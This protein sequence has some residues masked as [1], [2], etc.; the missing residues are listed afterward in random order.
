M[1]KHNERMAFMAREIFA[2]LGFTEVDPCTVLIADYPQAMPEAETPGIFYHAGINAYVA[3]APEIVDGM[4]HGQLGLLG[5]VAVVDDDSWSKSFSDL[6]L[7]LI[8]TQE[9]PEYVAQQAFNPA[10]FDLRIAKQCIAH[11]QQEL[12]DMDGDVRPTRAQFRLLRKKWKE[13]VKNLRS[14][15]VPRYQSVIRTHLPTLAAVA[16]NRT[17]C[18]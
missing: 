8:K 13:A 1:T 9:L 15:V 18:G 16:S 7:E 11:A 4:Y 6:P 2:P 14:L 5:A 10:Y 17:F 12:T 3:Y